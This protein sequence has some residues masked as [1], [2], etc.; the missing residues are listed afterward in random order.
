MNRNFGQGGYLGQGPSIA[1]SLGQ[2]LGHR[3]QERVLGIDADW[4]RTV[5]NR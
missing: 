2:K 1:C 5:L 4:A 3:G